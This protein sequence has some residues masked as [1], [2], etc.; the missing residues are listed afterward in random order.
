MAIGRISGPLLSRNLLRDGVDLAFETDLLYLDVTNGRIGVRK[1]NPNYELDVNGTINALKFKTVETEPGTGS[2]EIGKLFLSSGTITTTVG[3]I[4][5]VP[6]GNEP[7]IIPGGIGSD[8]VPQTDSTYNLGSTSSY[9][10]NAYIDNLITKNNVFEDLL[11]NGNITVKGNN[12]IGTAPVVT[13]VLYVTMDGKDTNDG[14]AEDSNRACRTITGAIRS[15]YYRP[16]TLIHVRSGHYYEDNPLLLQP[17]T[18][19]IG[20]DLRT[21]FIEPINKTQDLFHVQSGC[22]LAQMAFLNGRSG[23]LPG[24]YAPGFNRGAYTTAFPP[25]IGQKIDVYKSPY[26][27]NCT[28]QSGPWLNDG[29]MFI[30]NQTVQIP[31]AVG[32]STFLAN[33]TTVSVSLST[34]TLVA[35]MSINIGPQNPGFLN[36]RT[37]LLANKEFIKDQVVAFVNETFPL[38]VYEQSKCARDVGIIV[39]NISYDATFGGNEKS[40]ESGLAYYKGVINLIEGQQVPTTAAINYINTLSQLI[41]RNEVAPIISTVTAQVINTKL[42]GGEIASEEIEA[43]L[44]IVTDIINNGVSVA[45]TLFKGCGPETPS[46]SAETLLQANRAFLQ[47]EVTAYVGETYPTFVYDEAKCARDVGL[48]V[49]AVS[50]DIILGG[51]AKT[52]EAA[53]TYFLRGISVIPGEETITADAI[54]YLNT[55]S[56]DVIGNIQVA[57]V[58]SSISQVINT[59]FDHGYYL[60]TAVTRNYTIIQNVILN[61]PSAAPVIYAGSGLFAATGLSPDSLNAALTIESIDS[62]SD[63]NYTIT[64][65]TSTVGAVYN[66]TLYFGD[67]R[68]FPAQDSAVPEHWASRRVD[69]LGSMG[70]ALVDGGVVSERSRIQSFVFDAFTQLNQGGRGVRV[71]NN[72]YAQL[73]SVF[74]IFCSTAVQVDNGGICSITNSNSNFGDLCL[75]AKGYGKREFSGTIYNPPFPPYIPNGEY[76]PTGYYPQNGVVEVYLPDEAERAHIS[77]VMEVEPP[78]AYINDQAFPGFLNAAPVMPV[79][80][81]GTITI[82]GIDT[83]GIA[84]GNSLYIRDQ[85]GVTGYEAT[86]TVVVDVGY[87]SVTL[88][89][90]LVSGGGDPLNPSFFNLYFC[91]NAYYTVLSSS[92]TDSHSNNPYVIPGNQVDP[93]INSIVYIKDQITGL[94]TGANVESTAIEFMQSRFDIIVDIIGAES[95][96]VAKSLFPN[97][98]KIGTPVIGAGLAIQVINSNIESIVADTVAFVQS[99]N[100]GLE[101]NTAKCARDVRLLLRQM[102]YDLEFGGNYYSVYS[103]LS[104]WVRQGTHHLVNLEE[105]VSNPALFPDGAT[106]NFYQRSYIS[107]S[108]YLF[109]YVGAGSN[110]GALPQRGVADPVQTKEVVQL[111]NGKV[112]FTSTDQNG[113]FRIGPGLVVSQATGVLS[114]RTFSK[115]L[116][117]NLTP[118]ILAID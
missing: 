69:P 64:L 99:T 79:L 75:V 18:A 63:S 95:L 11:V 105:G 97:P 62:Q 80:N 111:D 117:A 93:E 74:T 73:V 66:G 36:A 20:D 110:Y 21:T 48:I 106:V 16:G 32:T 67:T 9:W 8:L 34:G 112:F 108:G 58:R 27:Q 5:I 72:G 107:A 49:D 44:N 19:I 38:F 86:G 114:G 40:V 91:G 103:G 24:D 29:T 23:V 87:Q 43:G 14:R 4:T 31:E 17:S 41:I 70:G 68:V 42:T 35:G 3:P 109:E 113:D 53:L 83:T 50:Q 115:S 89:K 2:A 78:L 45:P 77:L 54:A 76:Y 15:P 30:P 71:T 98:T 52:I 12:P 116:F 10:A 51:N 6:S 22:Y 96:E 39:E 118:F 26:I 37:L 60:N 82:T 102:N 56:L 84:V 88:N 100:P 90:G 81:T 92:P 104:Y 33:T 94:L 25:L 7:V 85:F 101:F 55:I 46:V 13:N 59:Y 47:A 65:S 1:N 61:G 57:V 28:N